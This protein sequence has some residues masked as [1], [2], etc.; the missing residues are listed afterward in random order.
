MVGATSVRLHHAVR[1]T[2]VDTVITSP[3]L[4]RVGISR[5]L[6]LAQRDKA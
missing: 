4:K 6:A 3:V 5:G 1:M 2:V